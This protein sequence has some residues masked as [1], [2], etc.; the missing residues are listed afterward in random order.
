MQEQEY[1]KIVNDYIQKPIH[2]YYTK[3]NKTIPK[4]HKTSYK[5]VPRTIP[6]SQHG[7]IT[8]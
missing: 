4:Q 1:N 2:T 5:T 3:S 7:N 8:T 6:K